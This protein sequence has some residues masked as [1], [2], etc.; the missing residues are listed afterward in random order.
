MPI[1]PDAPCLDLRTLTRGDGLLGMRAAA[2]F[3]P[4]GAQLSVARLHGLASAGQAAALHASG[5]RPLPHKA[6]QWRD[7]RAGQEFGDLWSLPEETQFG[8]FW[9][10]QVP[11]L[12]AD[13]WQ[14]VVQPGFMHIAA[15]VQRWHLVID[16]A[17]GTE[18]GRLLPAGGT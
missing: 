10:R 15:A 14:V 9:D 7:P 13:G 11:R 16:R 5:L 1:D 8:E 18:Q 4:R 6:L 17:S 12:Q 2:G 3:G